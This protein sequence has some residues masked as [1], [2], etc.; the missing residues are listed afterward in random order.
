MTEYC[1]NGGLRT[2]SQDICSRCLEVVIY[3]CSCGFPKYFPR[4][5]KLAIYCTSALNS[6]SFES[7]DVCVNDLPFSPPVH[8]SIEPRKARVMVIWECGWRGR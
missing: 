5:S 8:F 6:S 2:V 7:D 3:V 1:T 4:P